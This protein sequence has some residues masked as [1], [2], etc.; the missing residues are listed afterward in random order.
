MIDF[1]AGSGCHCDDGHD[2]GT[3]VGT[4]GNDVHNVALG[5]IGAP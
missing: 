3:Q 5:S 1:E 2:V 4:Q